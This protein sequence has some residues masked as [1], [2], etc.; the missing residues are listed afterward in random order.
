M[1]LS[2]PEEVSIGCKVVLTSK[3]GDWLKIALSLGF[4]FVCGSVL[5]QARLSMANGCPPPLLPLESGLMQFQKPPRMH[6]VADLCLR[7]HRLILSRKAFSSLLLSLKGQRVL[8]GMEERAC[9][10]QPQQMWGG[11]VTMQSHTQWCQS[12]GTRGKHLS[13]PAKQP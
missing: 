5:A 13:T 8:W 9:T 4:C 11:P 2:V 7:P 6:E 10:G 3:N 1:Q 12:L